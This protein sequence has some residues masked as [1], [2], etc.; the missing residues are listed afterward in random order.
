MRDRD[1]GGDRDRGQRHLERDPDD[2][3]Q[4]RVTA[5]QQ[6]QCLLR[7]LGNRTHR[8]GRPGPDQRLASVAADGVN[9]CSPDLR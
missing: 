8:A 4:P 9:N 5:E 1:R 3:P 6:D 2:L 7:A